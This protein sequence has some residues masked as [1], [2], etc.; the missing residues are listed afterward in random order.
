M[1]VKELEY[2]FKLSSNFNEARR[3]GQ[4]DLI[5]EAKSDLEMLLLHADS[6]ALQA[7]AHSLLAIAA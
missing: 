2:F 3:E 5:E 1:D 6:H 4:Q 7:R